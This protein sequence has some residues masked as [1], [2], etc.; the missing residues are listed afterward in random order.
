MN[1]FI[2]YKRKQRESETL[3]D[4]NSYLENYLK[5]CSDSAN[6][7]ILNFYLELQKAEKCKKINRLKP[8]IHEPT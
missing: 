1:Q 6:L 4:Y 7:Q 2:C 3:E 5:T 8:T